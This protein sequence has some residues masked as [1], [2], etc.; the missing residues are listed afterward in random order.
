[1][2]LPRMVGVLEAGQA[3]PN[4]GVLVWVAELM[5]THWAVHGQSPVEM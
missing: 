2:K 1:M 3:P 4:R 5:T